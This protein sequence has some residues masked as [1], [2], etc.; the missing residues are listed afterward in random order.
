MGVLAEMVSTTS[1][2][3]IGIQLQHAEFTGC[4]LHDAH[5]TGT[6]MHHQDQ[7][8]YLGGLKFPY[9]PTY[10]SEKQWCSLIETVIS[11]RRSV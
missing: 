3:F 5:P 6:C 8:L 11:H 2:M 7:A 9:F 4:Q 10:T 1:C